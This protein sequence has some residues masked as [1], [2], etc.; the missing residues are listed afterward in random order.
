MRLFSATDSRGF[1]RILASLVAG[2]LAV[3]GA[4]PSHGQ[5]QE[6][7]LHMPAD[8]IYVNGRI[9]TGHIEVLCVDECEGETSGQWIHFAKA[10]AIKG[11]R[12]IAVGTDKEIRKLKG[13]KTE[14]INLYGR[15][16]LPG[17]NDAHTHLASGGLT[18]LRVNLEGSKSLEEM[19]ARIAARAKTAG[20]GE[21]LTG[22]GWDHTLW[23]GAKLPTRQDLDA[24]T[25][26]H[27]A[28]FVRVDGHIA[29]ANSAA[30]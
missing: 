11:D 3:L 26:A 10:L 15:T 19:K 22:R 6:P 23:P 21:W 30:L 17:F 27:P 12:V 24:V 20:E 8:T 2:A 14:V 7:S 1:T 29:I 4:A 13:E 28:V 25:G 16:V 9:Y 18:Q 5:K